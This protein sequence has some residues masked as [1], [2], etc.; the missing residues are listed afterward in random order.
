MRVIVTLCLIL[1]I[2][3]GSGCTHLQLA[4]STLKQSSTVIDIQYQQVLDNLAAFCSNPA[5]LP[6]ISVTGTG[7]TSINDQG[8]IQ[9]ELDWDASQLARKL[10]GAGASRQVEEQWT[11]A[12][13]V[14]PDKL[15]AIRAAYQIV[16]HGY[17]TDPEYDDLLHS[18]LGDDYMIWLQRDWYHVG[19]KCDVPSNACYSASCGDLYIWVMPDGLEGLSQLT[20]V[21]LNIA[22]LDPSPQPETPTKTVQQF[23]YKDGQIDSIETLIRPDPDAPKPSGM[24]V[25]QDFYNPLQSQIQLRSR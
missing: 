4:R 25:R 1:T 23:N 8:T 15:R 18:F 14:N 12:P 3:S 19:H 6:H 7:G 9:G 5:I 21:T 2:A 24:P 20:L 10:L 22:T 13:V 11:L 17:T 16:A